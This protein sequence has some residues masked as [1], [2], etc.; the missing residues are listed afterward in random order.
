MCL[1][2]SQ[3]ETLLTGFLRSDHVAIGFRLIK[4]QM[5]IDFKYIFMIVITKWPL[6]N[7]RI[8]L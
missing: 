5:N 3:T 8:K 2:F 7:Q 6:F 1:I 4:T